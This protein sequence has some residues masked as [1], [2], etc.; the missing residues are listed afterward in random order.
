MIIIPG[1][2]NAQ[3]HIPGGNVQGQVITVG[4]ILKVTE[5]D[6]R[7]YPSDPGTPSEIWIDNTAAI[8]YVC[9]EV[10]PNGTVWDRLDVLGDYV[11]FGDN[12]PGVNADITWGYRPGSLRYAR[13]SEILWI[14]KDSTQGAAVW[15][16]LSSGGSVVSV[17]GQTGVVQLY[18]DDLLDVDAPLPTN[19]DVLTW[20]SATSTW[21]ALAPTGGGG[22]YT[23]D[24]GLIA[25]P[26]STNFQL[27]GQTLGTGNLI[28]DTYI[29][30]DG[31]EFRIDQTGSS[32]YGLYL[33][34]SGT[35]LNSGAGLRADAGGIAVRANS[36]ES[37]A[38]EGI[39][40]LDYTAFLIRGNQVPPLSADSSVLGVLRLD[41]TTPGNAFGGIGCSIDFWIEPRSSTQTVLNTSLAAIWENPGP[42]VLSRL[43]RF[44]I[45]GYSN[46]GQLLNTSIR[47]DGKFVLHQYGQTPANFPGTPIWALGV[48]ALGNVIEFT[49][50]GGGSTYTVDNGLTA[51]TSTNFQLGG[52]LTKHT[53]INGAGYTYDLFFTNLRFFRVNSLGKS[54][55]QNTTFPGV[56]NGVIIDSQF[57]SITADVNSNAYTAVVSV[58]GDSTSGSELVR[59]QS[60]ITYPGGS[61]GFG[62]YKIEPAA[63]YL[64]IKTPNVNASTATVGQVLA[65]ANLTGEVEFINAPGGG[66]TYTVDNGLTP[67]PF[68]INN[69]QLGGNL[70]KSTIIST[71]LTTANNRLQIDA[72]QNTDTAGSLY[73]TA[74]NPGGTY[75]SSNNILANFQSND[76]IT[77]FFRTGSSYGGSGTGVYIQ[78][79]NALCTPIVIYGSGALGSGEIFKV[80]DNGQLVLEEYNSS[81][82]FQGVSGTSQGVLN[83]DNTG[84]VF[85]GSGGGGGIDGANSRRWGPINGS[86]APNSGQLRLRTTGGVTTQDPSAVIDVRISR[87]DDTTADMQSWFTALDNY[88]TANPN[89]AYIQ[90][91]DSSNNSVFGIYEIGNMTY[92]SIIQQYWTIGLTYVSGSVGLFTVGS[93]VT[94]SWV[95]FGADGTGGTGDSLS[96]FL[97]MGG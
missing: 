24:N 43:S 87:F 7:P 91:T 65:L 44:D 55:I 73:V 77:A 84:K 92:T 74:L 10:G 39:S 56:V 89:K 19:G 76:I 81:T 6:R 28:R 69:F 61:I 82:S 54:W 34:H 13:N 15:N 42:A 53:T 46:G 71:G 97:L 8:G 85:V 38:Y 11:A 90:I 95:L 64:Q 59:M 80:T 48:D 49:P 21:I 47:G 16:V 93:T 3:T 88:R 96:P 78:S 75:T 4:A 79:T 36:R 41:R 67:D 25:N 22:T 27:G 2:Y 29:T 18:L 17:N 14:C 20:D 94:F 50:G 86:V 68:N 63:A 83:V 45:Y 57:T 40:G 66:G 5:R 26:T 52:P 62:A 51:N 37:Y 31:Y 70:I 35:G 60:F 23:V 12:D 58:D 72:P 33:N 1:I 9:K 32:T 30:N